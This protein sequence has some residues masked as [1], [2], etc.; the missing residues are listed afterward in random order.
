[1]IPLS[2]RLKYQEI[3]GRSSYAAPW[4]LRF[5]E[6]AKSGNLEQDIAVN[7]RVVPN[8]TP[9]I[10]FARIRRFQLLRELFGEINIPLA[11]YDEVV[12]SAPLPP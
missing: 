7:L 12:N 11:I 6:K 1:M 10:A 8:S 5:V 4:R 9:L 3:N 2:G